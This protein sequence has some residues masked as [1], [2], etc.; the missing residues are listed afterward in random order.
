MTGMNILREQ[1]QAKGQ[2]FGNSE[3]GIGYMFL[4]TW[5]HFLVYIREQLVDSVAGDQ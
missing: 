2:H 5:F 1:F 4:A 3:R